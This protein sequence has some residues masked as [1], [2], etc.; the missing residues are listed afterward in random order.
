MQ[1]AL[2]GEGSFNP[3]IAGGENSYKPSKGE[4]SFKAASAGWNSFKNGSGETSFKRQTKNWK[5]FKTAA[6]SDASPST[7]SVA[8]S[9][10]FS[11]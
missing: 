10:T 4:S 6:G 3:S 8:N 11:S 2:D 7:N 5:S 9:R 1:K